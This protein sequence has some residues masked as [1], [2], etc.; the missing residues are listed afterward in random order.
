[1]DCVLLCET[2]IDDAN[3]CLYSLPGYNLFCRNRERMRRGGIAIY[4]RQDL[5]CNRRDDISINVEGEFESL[6]LEISGSCPPS[7]IG[8]IYRVPNTNR[9]TA[10][11]RFTE[12]LNNL[13]LY[14][15]CVLIGTD[16]NFDFL[17]N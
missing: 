10:I 5:Q 4:I 2:F 15:H 14:K 6:F 17:K 9:K 16:Q 11:D 7:L 8:E 13:K 12:L 3:A 1:M